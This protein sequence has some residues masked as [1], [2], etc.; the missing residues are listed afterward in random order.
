MRY[1]LC[2][3][4]ETSQRW[5]RHLKV[6]PRLSWRTCRARIGHGAGGLG[7]ASRAP[8]E[9]ITLAKE[10]GVYVGRKADTSK[11]ELIRSLRA[12]G[13]SIAETAKLAK[14][15]PSLVKLVCR[16]IQTAA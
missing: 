15:S 5:P 16:A 9:G 6:P 7:D 8:G 1:S 14:C 13:H 11:H 4:S 10:K 3:A 2:L 12:A